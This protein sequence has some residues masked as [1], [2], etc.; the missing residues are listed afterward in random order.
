MARFRLLTSLALVLAVSLVLATGTAEAVSP[1]R[2]MVHKINNYRA[3]NGLSRL[4]VSGSLRSSA[5]GYASYLMNRGV[6]AHSGRIQANSHL[7]GGLLGE[8]LEIHFDRHARVG[9]AFKT[10]VR[11]PSH[12]AAMLDPRFRWVGAGRVAGR[13]RGH[14][15]TIWVAHFGRR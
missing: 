9:L 12:R 14:A 10:W 15:A 8:I 2:A 4:R 6:F 5:R 3:A 7:F 1:S 13:F 11:S